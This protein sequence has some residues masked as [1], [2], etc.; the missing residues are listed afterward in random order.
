MGQMRLKFLST[1]ASMMIFLNHSASAGVK[2]KTYYLPF[3]KILSPFA[4]HI[5]EELHRVCYLNKDPLS[6]KNSL[7]SLMP[8]PEFE[9]KYFPAQEPAKNPPNFQKI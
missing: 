7:L 6:N 5:S 3:I 1:I 9:E 8:W 4:P 2:D